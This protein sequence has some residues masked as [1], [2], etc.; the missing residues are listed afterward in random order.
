MTG[1]GF[2]LQ[3]I[4][5][6]L[7]VREAVGKQSAPQLDGCCCGTSL[8]VLRNSLSYIATCRN[9]AGAHLEPRAPCD[10]GYLA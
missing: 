9:L 4:I 3:V 10:P 7:A 5:S 8:H 6:V 2:T 1:S